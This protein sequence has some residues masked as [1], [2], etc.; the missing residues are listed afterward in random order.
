MKAQRLFSAW[1]SAFAIVGACAAPGCAPKARQA[2]VLKATPPPTSQGTTPGTRAR[3]FAELLKI[4]KAAR[5]TPR[6][7]PFPMPMIR[8]KLGELRSVALSRDKRSVAIGTLGQSATGQTFGWVFHRDARSG[9]LL[10]RWPVPKGVSDL[11]LSPDGKKLAT[12]GKDNVALWSWPAGKLL[13]STTLSTAKPMQCDFS[14]DGQ[15]LAVAYQNLTLFDVATLKRKRAL[16]L[17]DPPFVNN[18]M[19]APDGRHL[20]TSH[21]DIEV[22]LLLWDLRTRRSRTLD[23]SWPM[24]F[25]PDGRW[26]AASQ[27]KWI[28]DSQINKIVLFDARLGRQRKSLKLAAKNSGDTDEGAINPVTFSPDS[29][30]LLGYSGSDDGS[31]LQIWDVRSGKHLKTLPPIK[32]TF[33][34]WIEARVLLACSRD[35]VRRVPLSF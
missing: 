18:V 28:E 27:S 34:L 24:V 30:Y 22:D 32:G 10:G 1:L 12:V 6:P 23:A 2:A 7:T 35:S 14:P 3:D 17:P 9:V 4:L 16:P 11:A 26:L 19:F 20:A 21:D 8:D 33:L 29:R 13:H 5:P 31:V 15:T 25:S